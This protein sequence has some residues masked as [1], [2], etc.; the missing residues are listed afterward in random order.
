MPVLRPDG[1]DDL[2]LELKFKRGTGSSPDPGRVEGGE[3]YRKGR[4]ESLN[5]SEEELR[6]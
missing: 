1:F 5:F 2:Q 3:T 6:G 4:I